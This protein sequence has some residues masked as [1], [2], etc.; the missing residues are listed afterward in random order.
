MSVVKL[1][2]SN[3]NLH[4]SNNNLLF[5]LL[6]IVGHDPIHDFGKPHEKKWQEV[7][8]DLGRAQ[9]NLI[10]N[11][12]NDEYEDKTV[13][14][15]MN[16]FNSDNEMVIDGN[17]DYKSLIDKSD[18]VVSDTILGNYEDVIYETPIYWK[19]EVTTGGAPKRERTG[20]IKR[21]EKYYITF[22][23]I[24]GYDN[25]H[26]IDELVQDIEC[27]ILLKLFNFI[28]DTTTPIL[29]GGV[30]PNVQREINNMKGDKKKNQRSE[31]GTVKEFANSAQK[32]ESITISFLCDILINIESLNIEEIELYENISS[33]LHNYLSKCN[34]IDFTY[35]S[36][37]RKLLSII[38]CF[39]DTKS[40]EMVIRSLIDENITIT[41]GT[42]MTGGKNKQVYFDINDRKK[43][44]IKDLHGKIKGLNNDIRLFVEEIDERVKEEL[45]KKIINYASIGNHN[46]KTIEEY[47]TFLN[48]ELPKS[49]QSSRSSLKN[50]QITSI[51]ITLG[52]FF[53]KLN[54]KNKLIE[55]E[56][57]KER[58]ASEKKRHADLVGALTEK[59]KIFVKHFISFIAKS[60]LYMTGICDSS[61]IENMEIEKNHILEEEIRILR[62]Q[63]DEDNWNDGN[64]GGTMQDT[65]LYDYIKNSKDTYI[66]ISGNTVETKLNEILEKQGSDLKSIIDNAA[67]L[68][69]D[70]FKNKTFCPFTSILDGMSKCSYEKE[71]KNGGTL[72]YGNMDFKLCNEKI[73]NYYRGS[74]TIKESKKIDINLVIKLGIFNINADALNL[75]LNS[76]KLSAPYVLADTIEAIIEAIGKLEEED[77]RTAPNIFIMMFNKSI[78]NKTNYFQI[79]FG[80][81]L[82]KGAGDIFQEINAIA[83]HGG[84]VKK[85][86][87][88]NKYNPFDESGNALRCFVANDRVSVIRFLF[89]KKWGRENEIN[90][91]A[92]GGYVLKNNSSKENNLANNNIGIL[93]PTVT[94]G[95]SILRKKS[96]KKQTRIT[97]IKNNRRT[98]KKINIG[99]TVTIN[100]TM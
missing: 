84:Y 17:N 27:A 82:L 53:K 91:K 62:A 49:S 71:K 24:I 95:S 69:V 57:T 37:K 83:L 88:T 72:E 58:E 96:L 66:D 31:N 39:F 14:Y 5:L 1:D 28:T 44:E 75:E 94:G 12:E 47:K 45:R 4:F 20:N 93:L 97:A 98:K 77:V 38:R 6:N 9:A 78:L 79:F 10:I 67:T 35:N 3:N 26:S 61:G 70:D 64:N 23:P 54:D 43:Y 52:T 11:I 25:Q 60:A 46:N 15:D 22:L 40:I 32:F 42:Y 86:N 59:E 13:I 65:R 2:I 76:K 56:E 7:K 34:I 8:S 51:Q 73:D 29:K 16:P 99:K 55:N 68:I 30:V 63:I 50:K 85:G 18:N 41:G 90:S 80:R 92:F 87:K 48:Y 81:I 36:I 74:L 19:E 89:I 33:K 100:I 21:N